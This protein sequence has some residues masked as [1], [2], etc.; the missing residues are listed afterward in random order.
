MFI[1]F[2]LALLVLLGC[3]PLHQ[4]V[5]ERDRR[6]PG[7]DTGAAAGAELL[8]DPRFGQGVT[9][10]Y[11]NHLPPAERSD[12]LA[13][14]QSRGITDAQWAFWEISEQSSVRQITPSSTSASPSCPERPAASPS[15]ASSTS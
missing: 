8:R 9:Q 10:G 3:T 15:A 2:A 11:A 14:W 1:T 7:N 13:R 4:S 5:P 6:T 12:C